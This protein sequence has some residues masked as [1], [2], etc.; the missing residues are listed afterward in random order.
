LRYRIVLEPRAEEDLDAL[1]GRVRTRIVKALL[2]LAD[3]P[4][5]APNVKAL[6]GGGYR[7]RVGDYRILYAVEEGALLVLVVK[8]GHRR[9]VYRGT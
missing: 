2:R 5:A 6:A 8:V 4:F 9:E 1:D 3:D 7:L